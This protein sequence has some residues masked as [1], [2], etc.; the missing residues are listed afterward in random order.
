MDARHLFFYFFESRSDPDRDDV[1]FWTTGGPGGSSS[2]GLFMELGARR[3]VY[4]AAG[5]TKTK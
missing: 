4:R 1:I 2:L 3:D 5:E